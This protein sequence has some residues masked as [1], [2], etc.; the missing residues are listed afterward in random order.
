MVGSGTSLVEARILGRSGIGF[1][2]D[3]LACL[4]A[5]VKTRFINDEKIEA[6]YSEL[7]EQISTSWKNVQ[8]TGVLPNS[9]EKLI[10]SG[11]HNLN[12][13]FLPDVQKQ[14]AILSYHLSRISIEDDIREFL[15]V[16]YSG[17]I[18]TKVSVANARD[19]IHSRHHFFQHDETPD[20]FAKYKRR[21]TT[22]R[23]R[24][25][26][27]RGLCQELQS[28]SIEVKAGD[29]RYLPLEDE[30]VDFIFTSPPYAIALDYPR[31]HFLAVGWMKPL[32]GVD[33]SSYKSK[34]ATYIGSERGRLTQTLGKNDDLSG[35][36][37]A[38]SAIEEIA[39]N[40]MRC[41]K[42]IKRYFIDVRK[43]IE[44][45]KRVLKTDRHI[46][47]VVCPSHIRKVR[48]QTHKVINEMARTLNLSKEQ[49]YTRTINVRR[50]VLPYVRKS[51]GNRMST[52][53]V[54]VYRKM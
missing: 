29:A 4:I 19:I 47:I 12:Y 28:D 3:P 38:Q 40:D 2:I 35:C 49:E 14:L 33:V 7:Q 51:F 15:W 52:E 43:V 37:L 10:P 9:I 44:E 22:M 1:D 21:V 34:G 31:A 45:M 17:I 27:Y 32:F 20:V 26:E 42:L 46:V 53:Y 48:V 13:W 18:L 23:R 36:Y 50:R 30:S 24:M 54:L 41:A 11:F 25:A 6:A 39:E 5:R 16:A 8:T